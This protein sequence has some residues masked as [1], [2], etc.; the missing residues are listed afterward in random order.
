MRLP[1]TYAMI[2]LAVGLLSAA[3]CGWFAP[4]AL[5]MGW[6]TVVA[7]VVAAALSAAILTCALKLGRSRLLDAWETPIAAAV[8]WLWVAPI[9]CAPLIFGAH[10][11]Y[12][13]NVDAEFDAQRGYL[14]VPFFSVRNIVYCTASIVVAVALPATQRPARLAL[15]LIIAFVVANM[16]G[17][18]WIMPLVPRWHSSDFGL[19]WCVNGL[20][21]AASL[22]VAWQAINNRGTSENELRARIDGAT[23]LFAL[24]LGWLYL[25]F[26][27]YITAWSGN[28]P[29]E[30]SWYVPRVGGSWGLLIVAIVTTHVFIGTLLLSRLI[31][32]SPKIL[33]P[34]AMLMLIAQWAE[35]IWTVIP[36]IGVNSGV[37]VGASIVSL[38]IV[39]GVS[40]AWS[41]GLRMSTRSGAHG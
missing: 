33:L 38:I 4:R 5:L 23:L 19:R 37:A 15:L 17:F 30:A 25:M 35:A 20:L 31:K 29:D 27:D 16:I 13:W 10:A 9:L 26:V 1:S 28:L 34:L 11:L 24:D 40:I 22:A 36:G 7:P 41:R 8:S 6:L 39:V 12:Q 21:I 2:A 3:V 32:R 18:D 14:N